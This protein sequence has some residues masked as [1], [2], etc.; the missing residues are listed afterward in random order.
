MATRHLSGPA[1]GFAVGV[2]TTLIGIVF[3]VFL[4]LAYQR[5]KETRSWLPRPCVI[6]KS[7]IQWAKTTP[8]S[9]IRYRADIRYRY[10]LGDQSHTSTRIKR[11]DG[12]SADRK[13][14]EQVIRN[15]PPGSIH[16]C[17]VDPQ[18]ASFAILEH[19]TIAPIY[20]IWFPCLFILGGLGIIIGGTRSR[21]TQRNS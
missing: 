10:R 1:F 13:T 21:S 14:V 8:H 16:T 18:N 12:S 9:P 2:P 15:Y 7:E 6:E 4:Y 5:A 20:T 3:V 11:V 19:A 17:F